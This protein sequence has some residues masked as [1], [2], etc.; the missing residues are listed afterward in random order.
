[1]TGFGCTHDDEVDGGG[2]LLSFTDASAD[3]GEGAVAISCPCGDWL[4]EDAAGRVIARA[5]VSVTVVAAP[6]EN[7]FAQQRA[8]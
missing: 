8:A 7:T 3:F 2:N 5:E 6:V 4:I 1:M